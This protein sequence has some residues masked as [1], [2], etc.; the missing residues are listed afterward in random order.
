M[1]LRHIG[2]AFEEDVIPL[3]QHTTSTDV[4]K[5]SRSGRV[6]VLEIEEKGERY[7]VWDSLAICETL[8]ERHPDAKLWPDDA[9][10]RAIARSYSAEMHSSFPDVRDQLT[11]EFARR[12]PLPALRDN[13]KA[14]IE[15]IIA[16]WTDALGDRRRK[17]L[18]GF[19]VRI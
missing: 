10:A 4:Q 16:A 1:A 19:A 13:T 3:R 14:Q 17:R 6:P 11:M 2:V 7:F 18:I 9:K 15:R 8:A 5:R 12:M